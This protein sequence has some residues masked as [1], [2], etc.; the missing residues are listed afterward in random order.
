MGADAGSSTASATAATSEPTVASTAVAAALRYD[1]FLNTMP[2]CSQITLTQSLFAGNKAIGGGGGAIFWDG[3]VD[4]LVVSC[5]DTAE[6]LGEC[7]LHAVM[8]ALKSCC[9]M[10]KAS[11]R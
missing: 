8:L 7:I 4:D 5:S 1:D 11:R 9:G 3:P 2:N 10:S 6:S